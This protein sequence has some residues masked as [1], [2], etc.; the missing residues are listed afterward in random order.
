MLRENKTMKNTMKL[1]SLLMSFLLIFTSCQAVYEVELTAPETTANP[2]IDLNEDYY[3]TGAPLR[4]G[5]IETGILYEGC[6]IYIEQRMTTGIVGER[7]T[8]DGEKKLTYGDV[9]VDR[10]VKYNPVTGTVSSPCLIPTCNH[11]LE[12][13]C[14]MLLG[15]GARASEAYMFQGLFGDWLVYLR[16]NFDDEYGSVKSEIMYNM[17]TGE[18]R[19]VFCDDFGEEVVSKWLYGWYSDGKYYK[20][21]TVLDYSHTSYKPGGDIPISN[22]KPITKDYIYEYDFETN[23]SRMV[24]EIPGICG[25]FQ[26]THERFYIALSEDDVFS[27]KKDGTDKR[28][29]K[30]VKA[31]NFVG[32]YAIYGEKNGFIATDLRTNE[33]QEIVW[34]HSVV[35]K[36]C[37]TEKGILYAQQTKYD[38]WDNF[39]AKD[40][41][42]EHPNASTAEVNNAAKKLLASGTA[43]IWE[44][45]Y[46]GEDNKLIFELPAARIEIIS[47]YGDYVFAKVSKFNPDTG[48]NLEGYQ[49]QTCCINIKTGEITPIPQFE[50][51]VPY[52]YVN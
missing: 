7:T 21:N 36:M 38:E 1:V 47:A 3:T 4:A 12:S 50:I 29:E 37:I 40:Y 43:Q 17:K 14:P 2:E 20:I 32:T 48:A 34:D 33:A 51:I 11:S 18:L 9:R 26:V 46:L 42:K 24:Y 31:N 23:V 13:D 52:W 6:L 25:G 27:I 15:L 45:G 8:S 10:I 5:N 41:R 16:Y 30:L 44:C 22:Y 49:N 35:G 28:Q 19:S 39:S